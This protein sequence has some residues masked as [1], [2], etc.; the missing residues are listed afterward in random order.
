MS[1][2]D[3]AVQLVDTLGRAPG[4]MRL[5]AL[6]E[7]ISIPKSSA[8][9]L[10][11]E[12]ARH[13]L[14]RRCGDGEYTMG[15]RLVEWGRLADRSIGIRDIAAPVMATLRDQVRESV[16]L[17][18]RDGDS[19]VCVHAVEGPHALRPV[20]VLGRALPLGYGAAGKLLLAYADDAT[21]RRVSQQL[22]VH[23]N[24]T[25]PTRDDLATI[26]AGGWS[27]SVDEMEDGLTSLAA[28]IS[29]PGGGVPAALAI[30]GA[31]TRIA[32]DRYDEVR[33]LI[34]DACRE[35]ASRSS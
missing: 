11:V 27:V 18:V 28:P 24:R 10:L 13:G 35:I 12:L 17:Y 23:R 4:P 25:L 2:L 6:A 29:T 5:G 14:V 15:Y 1:V 30:A 33:G 16:H 8:H 20:A 32:P 7:E 31:T 22:P 26:R 19:R 34:S 3:K 9:R 21:V